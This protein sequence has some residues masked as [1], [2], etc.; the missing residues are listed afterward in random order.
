M[1][2]LLHTQ[3]Y[4]PEI[5]APQSRLHELAIHLMEKG[6]QVTVLTAMPSYPHGRIYDGYKGWLKIETLDGIKVIRTAIFPT[7]STRMLPRLRSYFTF[8]ISSL[9]IGF[10]MM[11]RVDYLFTESPPL[12]LGIT[13]FLLSRL[14]RARWI[15][16][17][18]DLWPESV[19]ELGL[20]RKESK[21]YRLSTVLEEFLYKR[22][23][24]VTGQ[25]K[26]ILENIEKRCPDVHTYHLSN[27]VDTSVFQPNGYHFVDEDFHIVYAGLHGLAQGLHQLLFAAQRIPETDYVVFTLVGEGPEKQQLI[28][29]RDHLGLEGI[30]FHPSVPKERIPQILGSAD[31]IVV[32][33]KTQLTGAVPSKLYEAMAMGKPVILIAESEAAEIVK[34][35]NCGVVVMPG[36]IDGL[37]SA[38]NFLKGSPTLRR[39]MGQNGRKAAVQ[40]YDRGNIASRFAQFLLNS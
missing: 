3:Y 28:G 27:G 11:G 30:Y 6:I 32:P 7:Q 36:D 15:F 16:N 8:V 2:I 13:G 24:V 18:A 33:L 14:K 35:A 9:L 37:V 5:G 23:W 12:F 4:P 19:V 39:Q 21:V 26:T 20:I 1:H 22:A 34:N 29:I 25:S 17:I 38:I 31:V 10:M 40:K